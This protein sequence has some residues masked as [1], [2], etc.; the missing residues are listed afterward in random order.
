[1]PPPCREHPVKLSNRESGVAQPE[2][3][4]RQPVEEANTVRIQK[5]KVN[6]F[7]EAG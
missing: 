7:T 6:I 3:A 1:M 2:Q 4:S 5:E